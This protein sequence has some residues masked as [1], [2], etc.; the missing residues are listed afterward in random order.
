VIFKCTRDVI[1]EDWR[2][3]RIW[4]LTELMLDPEPQPNVGFFDVYKNPGGFRCPTSAY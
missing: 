3:P 4:G 1:L 2:W